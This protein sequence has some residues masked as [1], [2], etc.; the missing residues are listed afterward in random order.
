MIGELLDTVDPL[1][2][3]NHNT[4]TVTCGDDIGTMTADL[5]KTR[6]ILL[7][8][9]SNASKFTRDGAIG[10]EVQRRAIEGRTAIEFTVTD[11]GVGMTAE[12][13]SKI[14][15][16][17]TQADVTTTRKYGGTGLGLALVSRF[18][19]LMGG[20]VFVESRPGSGSRFTVRLPVEVEPE[21]S[22]ALAQSGASAA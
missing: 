7:N 11:T 17:F 10:L 12:Q 3:K 2:Q 13:A 19:Q 8:L 16:P 20:S 21:M 18:C 4:L 6:Q 15:D 5:T 9:L 14:F 1:V 22:E